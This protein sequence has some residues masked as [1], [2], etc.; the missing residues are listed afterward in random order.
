MIHLV[1]RVRA[2][3]P[4]RTFTAFILSV[5]LLVLV[6]APNAFSGTIEPVNGGPEL[7][8][9]SAV[10]ET[11]C[12]RGPLKV[13]T[14]N[15]AHGR[16]T[17]F[18]QIFLSWQAIDK[19][20]RDISKVIKRE[21]ADVVALQEADG[22]SWWGGG[23]DHVALL[24]KKAG[25][26]WYSRAEHMDVW[27]LKYGTALLARKPY[28]ET[29]AYRFKSSFPTPPKGFLLARFGWLPQGAGTLKPVFVDVVS[30]HLDFSRS[31]VRG[32]QIAE[33]RA[34]LGGRK[35]PLIIVGDFNSAWL[36]GDSAVRELARQGG[37][38]VYKPKAADLGTY[39]SKRMDWILIS[40]G[41]EFIRYTVLP[42]VVSDHLGV[43]AV[44]GMK[45]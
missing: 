8:D 37:L 24:A 1:D 32:R 6:A 20:L 14:L 43:V 28:L 31:S 11:A 38:Q 5:L 12:F 36:A 35:N 27:A 23:F 30:V 33:M 41:L 45:P 19:N 39:G 3:F 34:F 40:A 22:P 25:F 16:K 26:P 29:R 18:S 44:I 9:V 10:P 17:S 4:E 15:M 13:I 2:R 42:D 21:G 7:T